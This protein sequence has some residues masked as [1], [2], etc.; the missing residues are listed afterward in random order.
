MSGAPSTSA[1]AAVVQD[2]AQVLADHELV[3]GV[4]GPNVDE[5]D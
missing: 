1:A 2:A 3:R 5:S 4:M